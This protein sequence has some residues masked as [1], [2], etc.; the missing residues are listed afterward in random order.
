MKRNLL[1]IVLILF[2]AST[3]SCKQPL[4]P[5]PTP[6]ELA[7]ALITAAGTTWKIHSVTVDGVDKSSL[8]AGMTLKFTSSSFAT[9]NGD[10][11]WPASG[12][13][14]FT[15]TQA[16]TI[17]RNDNVE[18][19][20]QATSTS[21]KLGLTWNKTTFEPG[22]TQSISGQYLFTFTP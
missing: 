22:R 3:F 8:F 1:P 2:V 10:P 9:T 15:S 5:E 16:T 18:V 6:E 17:K 14:D 20:V 11:L 13:W 4:P 21:L 7:T 19:Q 12:T